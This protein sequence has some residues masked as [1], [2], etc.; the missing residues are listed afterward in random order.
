MLGR[1]HLSGR[2]DRM[3]GDQR[4]RVRGA[5]DTYKRYR[6]VLARGLPQWPLGLPGWY[7]RWLALAIDDGSTCLLGVWYRGVRAGGITLDL[8]WLAGHGWAA[9]VLFPTDLP[10][11]IGWSDATRTLRVGLPTGPAARLFRLHRRIQGG[12]S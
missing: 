8:P 12:P 3:S 1:V 10:T 6:T 4:K 7:D 2:I 5:L 11:E 9:E